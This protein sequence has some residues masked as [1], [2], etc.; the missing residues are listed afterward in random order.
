MIGV[1]YTPPMPVVVRGNYEGIMAGIN[2]TLHKH[3]YHMLFVPL[4]DDPAEWGPVLLDQRMDGCMV[5]SR[6]REPLPALLKQSRLPFALVNAD[7]DLAVPQVIADEYDGAQQCTQHLI[8][9]GHRKITFLLGKPPT[10]YSVRDRLRG[11]NE[12]MQAGGIGAR[13]RSLKKA[14][15][16]S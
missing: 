11:Y 7:S 13:P 12:T 16:S 6:M 14:S 9:L 10:H 15:R 4:G 1:L 3:A 2:E 8:E 5:L